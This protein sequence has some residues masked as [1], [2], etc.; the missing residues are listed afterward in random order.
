MRALK[1]TIII[2]AAAIMISSCGKKDSLPANYFSFKGKNYA[3]TEALVDKNIIDTAQGLHIDQYGFLSVSGK[4]SAMFLIAVVDVQANSLTGNF[5]SY[6]DASTSVRRIL[7]MGFY[8]GS[9]IMLPS[10]ELYFTGLGGSI[11]IALTGSD[12]SLKFNSISAGVYSLGGSQYTAIDKIEGR[13]N[14]PLQTA[15]I[16]A[17]KGKTTGMIGIAK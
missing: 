11:D 5:A 1:F 16:T 13:Y 14:G 10:K 12:Y 2:A 6:D 3:I 7:S 15:V 8:G 9:L 4:D 17:S